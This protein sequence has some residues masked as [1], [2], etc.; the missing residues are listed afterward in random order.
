MAYRGLSNDFYW[1]L[2]PCDCLM[3]RRQLIL[4]FSL[5]AVEFIPNKKVLTQRKLE[6]TPN[7]KRTRFM[8][9]TLKV[10]A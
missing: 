5:L 4:S 10:T 9:R 2:R 8:E 3:R 7:N 1:H 6:V